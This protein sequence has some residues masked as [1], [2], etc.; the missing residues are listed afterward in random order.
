M[1]WALEG[2][3]GKSGGEE[4]DAVDI[5]GGFPEAPLLLSG[6]PCEAILKD[7]VEKV[8]KGVGVKALV[9]SGLAETP[10]KELG[11]LLE[12]EHVS[13]DMS[14]EPFPT[15]IWPPVWLLRLVIEWEGDRGWLRGV[16]RTSRLLRREV[17]LELEDVWCGERE[18]GLLPEE[19]C[20]VTDSNIRE[21]ASLGVNRG[22]RSN[23]LRFW[24]GA[25]KRDEVGCWWWACG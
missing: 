2:K 16:P 19:D 13:P 17:R 11:L 4:D 12:T 5:G 3:R 21:W 1:S 24:T 7:T 9:A 25:S 10:G 22:A 18:P 6:A 14:E 20:R 15:G 8:L 23:G